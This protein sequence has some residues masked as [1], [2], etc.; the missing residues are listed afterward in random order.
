MIPITQ[1]IVLKEWKKLVVHIHYLLRID[2]V[3]WA[4]LITNAYKKFSSELQQ[5]VCMQYKKICTLK[6]EGV[7]MSK[8]YR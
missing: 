1:F 2:E 3:W 5:Y 4:T 6:K 8:H 7:V